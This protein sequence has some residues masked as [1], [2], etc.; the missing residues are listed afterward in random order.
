MLE[1]GSGENVYDKMNQVEKILLTKAL[2]YV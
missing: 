1:M 2:K